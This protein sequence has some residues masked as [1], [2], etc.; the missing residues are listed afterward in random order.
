MKPVG[1]D[2]TTKLKVQLSGHPLALVPESIKD[3]EKAFAALRS[4][5]GDEES[6]P[7]SQALSS[8][9]RQVL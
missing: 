3:I 6:W 1:N 7:T 8:D 2:Q 9:R 4:Q 5:Y